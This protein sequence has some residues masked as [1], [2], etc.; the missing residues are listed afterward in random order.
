MSSLWVPPKVSKKLQAERMRHEAETLQVLETKT[1][2]DHWDRELRKIDPHLTLVRARERATVAGLK[3]GYWHIMRTVPGSPPH[4]I[5]LEDELGSP[6]DPGGWMFDKLN[7]DD[8]W[9]DRTQRE[10]R[11][12]QEA[13]ARAR[14]RHKALEVEERKQEVRERLKGYRDESILFSPDVP[15]RN[16]RKRF[17]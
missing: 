3:P 8:L 4:L 7:E 16:K 1:T 14:D 5:P 9:N 11:K 6:R 2:L 17:G 12:L 13:A 15:W 10:R